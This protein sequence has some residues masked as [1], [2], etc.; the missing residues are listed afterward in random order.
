MI[1]T[2]RQDL[3]ISNLEGTFD[4]RLPSLPILQ[5]MKTMGRV[6]TKQ[7][8]ENLVYYFDQN[9]NKTVEFDEFKQGVDRLV[10]TGCP[11]GSGTCARTRQR[12]A[13]T[14]TDTQTL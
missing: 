9:G 10:G 1:R 6:V 7:E 4:P 13:Q 5:A 11:H 14:Q 12:F 8:A 3:L 2:S